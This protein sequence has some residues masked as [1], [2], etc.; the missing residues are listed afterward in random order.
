MGDVRLVFADEHQA[1]ELLRRLA[2]LDTSLP[3]V[4]E[5]VLFC[6]EPGWTDLLI[7][8]IAILHPG[9]GNTDGSHTFRGVM[10]PDQTKRTPAWSSEMYPVT[11]TINPSGGL[12]IAASWTR[13]PLELERMLVGYAPV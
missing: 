5:G 2:D 11:V 13:D 10:M 9:Q 3:V 7:A 12:E 6:D 8:S 4:Y 1:T